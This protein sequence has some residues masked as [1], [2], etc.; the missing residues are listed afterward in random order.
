MA[1]RLSSGLQNRLRGFESRHPL[2][3]SI[4][5]A[6]PPHPF[7]DD[8]GVRECCRIIEQSIE[9]LEVAG[10]RQAELGL[11][12]FGMRLGRAVV[13]PRQVEDRPVGS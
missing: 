2:W 10:H 11:D 4:S 9:F 6:E 13:S 3:L 8:R 12:G 1:E 7:D 5:S